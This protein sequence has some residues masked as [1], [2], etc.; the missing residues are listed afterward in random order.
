MSYL[1]MDRK[2]SMLVFLSCLLLLMT[3]MTVL[4]QI[5]IQQLRN[6][7]DQGERKTILLQVKNDLQT[8][9]IYLELKKSNKVKHE[10]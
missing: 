5:Q 8:R 10:F 6:N 4:N 9:A 1:R 2:S 7:L 3:V